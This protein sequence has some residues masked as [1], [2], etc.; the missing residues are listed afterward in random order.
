MSCFSNFG[1]FLRKCQIRLVNNLSSVVFSELHLSLLW[2]EFRAYFLSFPQLFL[3]LCLISLLILPFFVSLLLPLNCVQNCIETLFGVSYW[4]DL[5]VWILFHQ[6]FAPL[7]ESDS[8]TN[9]HWQCQLI[10]LGHYSVYHN[11]FKPFCLLLLSLPSQIAW[12]DFFRPP[13]KPILLSIY[14]VSL[15]KLACLKT[16]HVVEKFL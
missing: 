3:V 13:S 15:T 8:I 7:N 6:L 2:I 1:L 12:L 5:M 10:Y 14:V 4:R 11:A 9:S 16:Y